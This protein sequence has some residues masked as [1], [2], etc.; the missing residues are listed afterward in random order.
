MAKDPKKLLRTMIVVCIVTGLAALAVGIVAAAMKEYIIAL[1]ML[2]VV[3]WQV[4][5]FLQW[6]KR[7]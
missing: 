1:A 5:N 2:I 6:R 4:V 3:G 7:L